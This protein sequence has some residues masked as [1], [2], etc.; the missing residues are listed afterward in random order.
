MAS[1]GP[2]APETV[3]IAEESYQRCQREA[4]FHAFYDR[5]LSQGEEIRRKFARTD[6]AQQTKQLQHGLG[7]L[8]IYAK[9]GNPVMLERVAARHGP[10]DVDAP[11]AMYPLFMDTLLAT[12]KEFD[13]KCSADVERAWRQALAPGL[14]YMCDYYT[15]HA[16]PPATRA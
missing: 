3:R 2:V 7:L 1:S 12:V 14:A 11:P 13:A 9:H 6:F 8:F 4:F 16:G 10:S 15:R 5:L